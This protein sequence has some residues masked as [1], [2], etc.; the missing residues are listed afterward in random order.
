[1]LQCCDS[2]R[3]AAKSNGLVLSLLPYLGDTGSGPLSKLGM[4]RYCCCWIRVLANKP[5]AETY[6]NSSCCSPSPFHHHWAK[7]SAIQVPCYEISELQWLLFASWSLLVLLRPFPG[8]LTPLKDTLLS[9]HTHNSVSHQ[10]CSRLG[11]LFPLRLN[12]YGLT[13]MQ[14]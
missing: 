11:K 4:T 10:R 14:N 6:W 12:E 3:D 2:S 9:Q 13:V 8:E 7:I 5:T 1:M